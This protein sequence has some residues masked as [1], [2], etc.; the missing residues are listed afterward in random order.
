MLDVSRT[1]LTAGVAGAGTMGRGI[2]QVLA[3]SGA[4]TLLY[5]AQPGSAQKA[6]AAI[7]DALGKQVEKGRL[8]AADVDATL[9]RIEVIDRLERL[10]P[11]HI[12]VE[13]IVEDLAAKRQLF[14]ALEKTV[15]SD[16]ILASNTS[17]LSVTE[18]AA[19]CKH[20]ERVAG[21]H[22]FNPVPVMKIVEVV[23]GV[24]TAPWPRAD[25]LQGHARVRRQPCRPRLRP[26]VAAG[27]LGRRHRLRHHR[28]YPRRRGRIPHW[29][30]WPDGPRRPRRRALGDEVDVPAVF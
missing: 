27:S 11:G 29:P 23:D 26:R 16:C 12:V 24:L 10:S 14:S 6:K 7:G 20:P 18:M 17:S 19:A 25:P 8:K 1:D 28:P 3:Q 15:A 30:V 13:A 2:A 9:G 21:Y 5:D 22:F 4:R